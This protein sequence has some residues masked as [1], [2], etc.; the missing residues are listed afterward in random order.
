MPY[1]LFQL[2]GENGI[3]GE[4]SVYSGYDSVADIISLLSTAGPRSADARYQR[5]PISSRVNNGIRGTNER[6]PIVQDLLR[7]NE[8]LVPEPN[9]KTDNKEYDDEDSNVSTSASESS[10]PGEYEESDE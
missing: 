9:K 6:D 10:H 1:N 3:S 4:H 8:R 7:M 5:S 2:S